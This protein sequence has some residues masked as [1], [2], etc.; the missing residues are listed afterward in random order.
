MVL[1]VAVLNGWSSSTIARETRT[2]R[3][4]RELTW[5]LVPNGMFLSKKSMIFFT[6]SRNVRRFIMKHQSPNRALLLVGKS[7][8]GRNMVERV[9]N[10]LPPA[11]RCYAATA[12]VTVDPCWPTFWDWRPNLN[13]ET[14]RL[15]YHVDRVVN[16]YAKLPEGEQAGA[17][18]ETPRVYA[19]ATNIGLTDVDHFSIVQSPTVRSVLRH[20]IAWL[21]SQKMSGGCLDE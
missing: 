2:S 14:L 15:K 18:V 20:T 6:R 3:L 5:G 17:K 10:K 9:V 1:V 7:L 12:L 21:S 8:G 4:V 16:V 13:D 19:P 11:F